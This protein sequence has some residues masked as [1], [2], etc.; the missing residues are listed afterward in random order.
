MK[1]LM[2]GGTGLI[3][4][5]LGLELTKAG[6]ELVILTRNPTNSYKKCPFPHTAL[7]WD[8][9]F[10][11]SIP[12]VSGVE[13]II[14][15]AGLGIAD[16]RWSASYKKNLT[17]SRVKSSNQ[18]KSFAMKNQESLKFVLSASAIGYY[19]KNSPI[20]FKEDAEAGLDFMAQLCKKWEAPIIELSQNSSVRCVIPRIG[21][22]LTPQGG[23]LSKM[24]P[25]LNSGLGGPLGSGSQMMS[26][27][28][29]YDLIRLLIH[30]IKDQN[31][32]GIY[33]AVSSQPKT[34]KDFTRALGQILQKPTLLPA[35]AFAIKLA[36]GEMSTL[37]LDGQ[38]ISNQKVLTSGF[39]FEFDNLDL[40]LESLLGDLSKLKTQKIYKQWI[41]KPLDQVWS[42]FSDPKNLGKLTPPSSHFTHVSQTPGDMKVGT[43][44]IHKIYLFSFLPVIWKSRITKWSPQTH[45]ADNQIKGPFAHWEHT[46]S[47]ESLNGGT[48]IIDHLVFKAP[49]G[50]PGYHLGRFKIES[51]LKQVFDFRVQKL[52]KMFG[53]SL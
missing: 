29:Q 42:F 7:K 41:P 35:P 17:D 23:A 10:D 15:L 26:W 27:I 32:K 49:L 24:I 28:H 3:G 52:H 44:I 39:K 50:Y 6:H 33:N 31:C 13:G 51:D 8:S 2:T 11:S 47:F 25:P 43:E 12:E 14:N 5:E 36:L 4:S 37:V 22:V 21:I 16:Q 34:N 53:D 46:H 20:D 1:V 30:L 45:F 38:K 19:P 48:L 9:L 18:V 40:A